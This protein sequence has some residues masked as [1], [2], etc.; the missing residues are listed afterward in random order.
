MYNCCMKRFSILTQ[1]LLVA[2]LTSACGA[3]VVT[4]TAQAIDLQGTI[5]A[6]AFTSVAQTQTAIPTA[7]PLPPTPIHTDTPALLPTFP[8]APTIDA[9]LLAP[10]PGGISSTEDPCIHQVLPASLV[11]DPIR[12]RIDNQTKATLNVSV[13]LQQ[14]GPGTQCGY[15]A[16]T[17]APTQSLVI[18]DLVVGCY[19]VWAWNPDPQG[20]FMV[21]NG[22][23]C[24]NTSSTSWTFDISTNGIRLR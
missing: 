3:K 17:L 18:N 13:Y 22:T 23:S 14:N 11:G 9:T 1:L 2:L 6:A 21:T 8:P 15:R 24:L 4:P 12:I 7:T 16:Y 20:Y 19:T 10:T 5:A